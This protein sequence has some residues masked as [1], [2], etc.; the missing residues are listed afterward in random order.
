MYQPLYTRLAL[1][2][3]A[4]STT[5]EFSQSVSM[6]GANAAQVDAVVYSFSGTS[7]AL[8]LQS[9][10]DLENWKDLGA[11]TPATLTAVGYTLFSV[12]TAIGAG[13]IRLKVTYVTAGA[14]SCVLAAGVNTQA[15]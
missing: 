4:A 11:P 15:L 12:I 2:N 8:Q 1:T 13:Y 5:T 10:N 14:A 9:S 7:V 6:Q 3:A